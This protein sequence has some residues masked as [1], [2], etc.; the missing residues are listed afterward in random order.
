VG[1]GGGQVQA[2]CLRQR[3]DRA[4]ALGEQVEQFQALSAAERLA[5]AGEGVVQRGL[6]FRVSHELL[7]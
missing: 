1:R 4:L 5:G 3:L 2:G 6:P 7:H